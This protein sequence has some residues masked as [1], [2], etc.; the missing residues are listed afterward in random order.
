MCYFLFLP[1]V[2]GT[3]NHSYFQIA[4]K[5]DHLPKVTQQEVAENLCD[6][7]AFVLAQRDWPSSQVYLLQISHTR[8]KLQSNG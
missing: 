3:K 1:K 7:A 4:D 5:L 6:T 8:N 2:L